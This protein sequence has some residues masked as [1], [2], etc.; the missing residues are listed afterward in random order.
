MVA[1]VWKDIRLE[2]YSGARLAQVHL[3]QNHASG[4]VAVEVRVAVQQWDEAPLTAVVRITAP[5]VT[6]PVADIGTDL[7]P[8][9]HRPTE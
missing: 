9:D 3:R 6:H 8:A 5:D 1:G 7:V 2:G 4:Q